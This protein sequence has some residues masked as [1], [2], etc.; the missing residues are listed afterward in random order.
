MRL[1][2]AVPIVEPARR[3]ILALLEQLRRAGWP[4]RWVRDEAIHLTLKFFGEVP[5]GRLDPIWEAVRLAVDSAAPVPLRLQELGA[6]PTPRR[7]RVI[8]VGL[9]APAALELL[10][11]R[12]E[13]GC[14]PI[15]FPSSGAPFRPHVTL[16]RVRG[17]RR[18]A[19]GWLQ[20]FAGQLDPAEFT[21]EEVVLYQSLL[22]A[23]GPR[24]ERLAS[25]PLGFAT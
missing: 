15:G 23:A 6:F 24:Y 9:E 12:L 2:A 14:A 21:A 1:F 16:G 22:T 25:L 4:V 18:L 20:P 7:A 17:G 3:A 8:W 19:A 5:A 13:R 10:Q 11:D